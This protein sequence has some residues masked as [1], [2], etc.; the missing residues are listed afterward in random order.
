MATDNIN[1]KFPL[2]SS[3]S[4]GL[5]TNQTTI[6]AVV[7]DLRMLILTNHND[8]VINCDMGANLRKVIFEQGADVASKVQDAII[9]AVERWMPFVDINNIEVRDSSNDPKLKINEVRVK[10][11]FSVNQLAGVLT[12]VIK[13]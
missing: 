2:Q 1:I 3:P 12:Q 5:K 8:R 7:D 13:S 4:G 10:I 11:D 6:E 9:V